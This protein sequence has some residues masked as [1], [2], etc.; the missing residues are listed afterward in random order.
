MTGVRPTAGVVIHHNQ[1]RQGVLGNRARCLRWLVEHSTADHVMVCEDDVVYCRW[2]R[3][4]WEVSAPRLD[5]VGFWS[6]CTPPG[7]QTHRPGF[8][9]GRGKPGP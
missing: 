2:A 9:L 8:G 5:T 1:P 4:A 7:P 6:L 3:R